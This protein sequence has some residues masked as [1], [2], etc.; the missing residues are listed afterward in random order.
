MSSQKVS[1]QDSSQDIFHKETLKRIEES[2]YREFIQSKQIFHPDAGIDVPKAKLSRKLFPF[3]RDIVHWA[4]RKGRAAIFADC[5]LGK[6]LMQLE[7]ARRIDGP[8]LFLAPLAVN[9]QTVWE[10][11]DKLHMTIVNARKECEDSRVITNYEMMQHF[12]P[13]KYKGVVL[14]ESSI[15][16]NFDGKFRNQIIESFRPIPY[17]L[18]CTATP[19]PNDIMELGNHS[20]F[21]GNLSRTE[22]LSTFFVHDGGETSKW[23]LKGHA[24]KDFWKWVCTWAVMLRKPSDLGYSDDG[25]ILPELRIHE[26]VVD[27]DDKA[28][29]EDDT[30]A[31]VTMF[32]GDAR[33]LGERRAAR[34]ETVD[35]RAQKVAELGRE[36]SEDQFLVW[37]N[38]N[39]E[40]NAATKLLEA[41]EITGS[42]TAEFKER[43]ILA[44]ANGKTKR[45][46]SKPSIC[47]LGMNLQSCHRVAFLGLSDSYESYYQAVRR[48]WRFGQKHPVDCYIVTSSLEGEVVKNIKRKEAEANKMAEEMVVNMSEI[49][50]ADIHSQKRQGDTYKT[51]QAS[52]RDW[53]MYLGDTCEVIKEWGENSIHYIISSWPFASLYTYSASERDAGNCRT[54]AE[55]WEHMGFMIPEL[56]RVLKPGRL[57]SIHCMNL[58]KS[59][60]RDGVIGITD[61]RGDVI[62]ACERAG[63]IYH[64]EVCIWK[65]PVTAMQR[66]KALGLLHKQIKKDSC[67][68]RQGIPDYLVTMRK[69]GENTER[70]DGCFESYIGE[71]GTGPNIGAEGER[72]SI[73]VW[74]RYSSPIW[75]DIKAGDT[76]QKE[77][78]REDEDERHICPLQLQV[79]ERGIELWSN[80]KDVIFDPFTGIGSTGYQALKSGRK[81]IGCE[82]KESYYKQSVANLKAAEIAQ[83][84]LF[85]GE[86]IRESATT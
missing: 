42:D 75:M 59:K 72:F 85:S 77:S 19:S 7:W 86:E 41:T 66:T 40:S 62:R 82:L 1:P 20:E 80:P 14:D 3:Q 23:R 15:L 73:E 78:V 28:V 79:I 46:V 64:S 35:E 65:D 44:F 57:M 60:E 31:Q 45:L 17:K 84:G 21:L 16:K 67:M 30:T 55:F 26:I 27:C 58:P 32:P 11:H 56:Y 2:S 39:K 34:S 43:E 70:V 8:V 22:M 4:L 29:M 37:C 50:K 33:T 49:N 51:S 71:D 76:L 24:Q 52:G 6:T 47:G 9:G 25:F 18:A 13:H 63:F 68:S 48:V 36:F 5:G 12:N 83:E 10:A 74:Q 81:F 61:F 69:P 54:H 38:L 53:N